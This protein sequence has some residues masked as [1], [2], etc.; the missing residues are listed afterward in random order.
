MDDI[1]FDV[2]EISGSECGKFSDEVPLVYRSKGRKEG[3][4][5]DEGIFREDGV[6]KKLENLDKEK[7]L[8]EVYRNQVMAI[9]AIKN[10]EQL[11]L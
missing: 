1:V 10:M 3:C 7:E 4:V 5:P 6:V 11:H 9:Q 8:H 2:S